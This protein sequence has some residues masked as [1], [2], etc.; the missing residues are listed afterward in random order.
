MSLSAQT[1]SK[2]SAS[3][4]QG[5]RP[6]SSIRSAG[7]CGTT[8]TIRRL[9]AA[10]ARQSSRAM[11]TRAGSSADTSSSTN[12]VASSFRSSRLP[13]SSSSSKRKLRVSTTSTFD[14]RRFE[15]GA[16]RM[17][18]FNDRSSDLLCLTSLRASS[19]IAISRL[20]PA[21]LE[22]ACPKA[23]LARVITSDRKPK[24]WR[25]ASV[26]DRRALIAA[27]LARNASWSLCSKVMTVRSSIT[28]TVT[29]LPGSSRRSPRPW[30]AAAAATA[31][32]APA[33][34]ITTSRHAV[35]LRGDATSM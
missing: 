17:E 28:L 10:W 30:A 1:A 13:L 18:P 20:P 15:G 14:A 2:P 23:G 24:A 22:G 4:R 9:R 26:L 19:P 35:A 25:C 16:F 5:A 6:L 34:T 31:A 21:S 33:G 27:G 8:A 7:R 12:S 11:V 29:V 32:L 3:F